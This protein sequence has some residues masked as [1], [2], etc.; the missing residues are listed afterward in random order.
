MIKAIAL[1]VI[2]PIAAVLI[3]AATRPDDFRVQRAT[4]IKAPPGKIFPFINEFDRWGAWSPYEK[5]DPAMK[6]SRSGPASGK[7]AVYAWEGN[8]QVGSGRMEIT[9]ASPPSKIVIKLDFL[10]PFEAHNTAEFMLEP[11]GDATNVTW[12]MHGPNR[13]IG[14]VMQVFFD[15]DQMIGKDFEAGLANLKSVAEK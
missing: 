15:M 11:K 3:F 14:K 13:Y 2:L 9:E 6:R 7:G 4:S 12:A 5:R 8:R 10:K 1:A